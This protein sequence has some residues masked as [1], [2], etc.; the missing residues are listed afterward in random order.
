MVSAVPPQ[1][2]IAV[3]Y[4][5]DFQRTSFGGIPTGLKEL[6]RHLGEGFRLV[7]VGVGG[8]KGDG[9]T[10][11]RVDSQELNIL[12]VLRREPSAWISLNLLFTARLFLARRLIERQADL[13]LVRRVENAIPFIIRKT[14]PIVLTVHGSTEHLSL[15]KEGYLRWPVVQK[16]YRLVEG[17]VLPGVDR[18]V[19]VSKHDHEYYARRY[20]R[21]REKFIAIP[22]SIDVSAF[23]AIDRNT[24]RSKFGMS[25]AD[26]VVA[27]VGRLS[28]EKRLDRLLNAFSKVTRERQNAHLLIAGEG[29]E[30]NRLEDMVVSLGL[31]NVTFLGMLT[32]HDVRTLMSCADVLALVSEFEG[33]PNVVLEALACGTP[34]V[35]TD[36]GGIREVLAD[37]LDHFLLPSDD[38]EI[39][40]SKILEAAEHRGALRERCLSRA[41]EFDSQKIIRRLEALYRGLVH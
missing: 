2:R 38:P 35:A 24:A 11:T 12:P 31:M 34:V 18:V 27:Y 4:A 10:R 6:A 17:M 33:A 5:T 8:H 13:I 29:A 20:P 14:K 22:N 9:E 25:E 7:F 21:L 37:G 36:V 26:L 16:L 3:V 19:F 23:S 15:F 32:R 40:K 28:P 1:I 41:R 39:I 30:R